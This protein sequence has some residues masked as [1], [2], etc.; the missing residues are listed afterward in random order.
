MKNVKKHLK[1]NIK[2]ESQLELDNVKKGMDFS[3]PRTNWNWKR[4][5]VFVPIMIVVALVVTLRM[6]DSTGIVPVNALSTVV[7]LDINPGIMIGLDEDDEVISIEALNADAETLL[8]YVDTTLTDLDELIANIITVA[9][10]QDYLLEDDTILFSVQS[11]DEEGNDALEEDINNT[12]SEEAVKLGKNLEAVVQKYK[13]ILDTTSSVISQAKA[14]LIEALLIT[15]DYGVEDIDQLAG[16]KVNEIKNLLET[17]YQITIQEIVSEGNDDNPGQ[18]KVREKYVTEILELELLT[19]EEI[20]V[21]ETKDLKDTLKD[22]Y[23]IAGDEVKETAEAEVE[24]TEKDKYIEILSGLGV[25]TPEELLQMDIDDLEELLEEYYES[26][27]E[28]NEAKEKAKEKAK[29]AKE[30]AEEKRNNKFDAEDEAEDLAE[31]VYDEIAELELEFN[32]KIDELKLQLEEKRENMTAEEIADM[33]SDIQE[34]IDELA[35]KIEELL[36]KLNQE[37]TKVLDEA[38]KDSVKA[39]VEALKIERKYMKESI[40][41]SIKEIA[42]LEEAEMILADLTEQYE[43]II[44][45]TNELL[46]SSG[47]S[48]VEVEQYEEYLEDIEED[49]EDLLEELKEM[50]EEVE[51]KLQEDQEESD[52]DAAELAEE[53]AK[54]EDKIAELT[55]DYETDLVV[56]ND[57]LTNS[58]LTEEDIEAIQEKIIE[59]G[60][61]YDE[62]L[63]ELQNE[64]ADLISGEEDDFDESEVELTETEKLELKITELTAEYEENLTLLNAELTGSGLT[65]EDIEVIQAKI[66]ELGVE[67]DE[68]LLEF[69]NELADL[70]SDEN[71]DDA[72]TESDELAEEIAKIEL[73]IAELTADYEE[74]LAELNNKLTG[75]GLSEEDITELEDQILAIGVEYNEDLLELQNELA[76]L[77]SEED[78]S[79]DSTE[80]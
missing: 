26:I 43:A 14:T 15:G 56:L 8:L 29:E 68:K 38:I 65:E 66:S 40:K 13:T 33:E 16:M 18:L 27:E 6:G 2:V 75:S 54:L 76:E 59:L 69:Q 79:D 52:K 36:E 23:K 20:A 25:L 51:E 45:S 12:V 9:E 55:A 80:A 41:D 42:T 60:I 35:S 21:M 46:A 4:S 58:G 31:D 32:T 57:E 7:T 71:D 50:I 72:D 74:E 11:E 61:E 3:K 17:S 37:I 28:D 5:M 34:L 48:E 47:L 67:Y 78:D 77:T 39:E 63:L 62:D 49:F 1:N 73:E 24:D 70:T 64:L 53:I 22:Y 10:E 44:L 19:L 30:K